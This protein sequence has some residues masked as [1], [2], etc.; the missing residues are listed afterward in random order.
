MRRRPPRSTRTD[1]L[2]PYTT[3]FRSRLGTEGGEHRLVDGARPER[4]QENGQKVGRAGQEAG[5]T[6][7]GPDAHRRQKVGKS[8]GTRP[9]RGKVELLDLPGSGQEAERRPTP[10]MPITKL[11]TGVEATLVISGQNRSEEHTSE[12]QSLMRNSYAVFCL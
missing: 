11:N 6:L 9:E 7:A 4:A 8:R 10:Y 5:D 2:F 1:T 3:L 12:L